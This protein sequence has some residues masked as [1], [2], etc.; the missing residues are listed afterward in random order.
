LLERTQNPR[1]RFLL[2]AFHRHRYLEIAGRFE[3]IFAPE[4]MAPTAVYHFHADNINT[5]LEGQDAVK[6]LYRWWSET[7]QTIFYV[8]DEQVAVADNF[9]ASYSTVHQQIWGKAVTMQKAMSYMPAF[10]TQPILKKLLA[11]KGAHA[12]ENAMYLYTTKLE[13]IWPYDDM[14][15]L[16]GEDIWEPDPQKAQLTKLDPKDVLTPARAGELL[17]SLIKP[18]PRFDPATMRPGAHSA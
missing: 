9:I 5:T 3:E 10:V 8:E 13:M 11:A 18:L 4:M 7:N 17:A 1:H 2:Q 6:S 12:D 16:I 14:G 15:R